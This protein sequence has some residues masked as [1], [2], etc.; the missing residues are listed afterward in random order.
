ML[1]RIIVKPRARKNLAKLPAD[2]QAKIY[3]TMIAIRKN[4]FAGKKLHGEYEE[5]YGARVW[6]YRIIYKVFSARSLIVIR[7]IGHRQGIY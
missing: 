5:H 6:P 3:R 7:Y 4:P 1:F 2:Y